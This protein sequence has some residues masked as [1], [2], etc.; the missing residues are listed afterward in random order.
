MSPLTPIQVLIVAADALKSGAFWYVPKPFDFRS[1]D[2]SLAVILGRPR[3][4][5]R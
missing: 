3:R 1:L 2:H 5:K 4:S